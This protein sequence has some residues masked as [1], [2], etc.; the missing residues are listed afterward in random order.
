MIVITLSPKIYL[1]ISLPSANN[2][3][4]PFNALTVTERT[5]SSFINAYS[6]NDSL[7]SIFLRNSPFK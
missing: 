5:E 7:T 6:P 4:G 3:T 1:I 2:L